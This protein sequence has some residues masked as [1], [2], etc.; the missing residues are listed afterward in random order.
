MGGYV[1]I[2]RVPFIP[3]SGTLQDPDK[4]NWR[5]CACV[6]V[7]SVESAIEGVFLERGTEGAPTESPTRTR[8]QSARRFWKATGAALSMTLF[9]ILLDSCIG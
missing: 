8:T 9:G 5:S 1:T 7:Q 2:R 3:S 4:S 6:W